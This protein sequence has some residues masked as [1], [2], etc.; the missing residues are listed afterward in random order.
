MNEMTPQTEFLSWSRLALD[1]GTYEDNAAFMEFKKKL[2]DA[3]VKTPHETDNTYAVQPEAW[4][5]EIML[6]R[7][8]HSDWAIAETSRDACVAQYKILRDRFYSRPDRSPPAPTSHVNRARLTEKPVPKSRST[9]PTRDSSVIITPPPAKQS[10]ADLPPTNPKPPLTAQPTATESGATLEFVTHSVFKNSLSA[11]HP[12][13]HRSHAVNDWWNAMV[14]RASIMAGGVPSTVMVDTVIGPVAMQLLNSKN[15]EQKWL[16][17]ST[18]S[19]KLKLKIIDFSTSLQGP[20]VS[21]ASIRE[22]DI[23]KLMMQAIPSDERQVPLRSEPPVPAEEVAGTAEVA[24]LAPPKNAEPEPVVSAS[25]PYKLRKLAKLDRPHKRDE[26][27]ETLEDIVLTSQTIAGD[28]PSL[29]NPFALLYVTPE[30]LEISLRPFYD[31]A[32]TADDKVSKVATAVLN[33]LAQLHR[34]YH[35][36]THVFSGRSASQ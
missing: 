7:I 27:Y 16:I 24:A 9:S 19:Q 33:H 2:C 11:I 18:F 13:S 35:E 14:G 20:G 32:A 17:D 3:A 21:Y 12:S 15:G 4:H 29:P 5:N 22:E 31:H 36:L 1:C 23:L 10:P 26:F 30:Q 28:V 25:E 6:K 8:G 34:D